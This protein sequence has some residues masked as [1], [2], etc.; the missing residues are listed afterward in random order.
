MTTP[1]TGHPARRV[2][3]L[4]ALLG[5]VV[6]VLAA[7][8]LPTDERVTPYNVDDIP[9][10]LTEQTTT[11]TSTTTTTVVT[12]TTLPTETVPGETTTTTTTS[13]LPFV[14]EPIIVYY[15]IGSS[16]DLRPLEVNR[17]ANPSTQEVIAALESTTGLSQ[18][19]LRT[20]VRPGLIAAVVPERGVATIV[21]DPAVL[22]RMS[23]AQ[24]RRAI[25]QMVLTF[26]SFRTA[27]QGN[28]AFVTFEADGEPYVVFVPAFD[29][30]SAPD[31]LLA[32]D[33]FADLIVS[34]AASTGTTTT[35]TSATTAPPSTG[36]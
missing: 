8:G 23:E 11:T 10:Q 3:V 28:I 6:G 16:S 30:M 12:T 19:G 31:D 21:L 14:P 24:Q 35:T 15:T 29:D 36:Q 26:T 5:T 34:G 13:T 27:D 33:D 9:D 18:L 32:F 4:L 20:S 17:G 7:C 22:D 1:G 2:A 25:A